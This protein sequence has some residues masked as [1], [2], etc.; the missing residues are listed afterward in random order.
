QALPRSPN[1]ASLLFERRPVARAFGSEVRVTL[2]L[3]FY[4]SS[5]ARARPPETVQSQAEHD[6]CGTFFVAVAIGAPGTNRTRSTRVTPVITLRDFQHRARRHDPVNGIPPQ[7]DQQFAGEGDDADLARPFAA[8]KA[9]LIPLRQ[10]TVPLPMHPA[11][12][13][14]D[15]HRLQSFVAGARNA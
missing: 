7:R 3:A 14:L 5:R 2:A 4:P 9:R 10:G 8:A 11:P 6:G 15:H 1:N 12:R 13:Q